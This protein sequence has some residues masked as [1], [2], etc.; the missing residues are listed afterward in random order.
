MARRREPVSQRPASQAGRAPGGNGVNVLVKI[1]ASM[2]DLAPAERRVAE[3]ALE[4]PAGTAGRTISQ[5]AAA[6]RTSEATVVRFCRAIGFSGYPDLRLALAAAAG[7]AD[8]DHGWVSGE[9]AADDDD[10]QI[11]EKVAYADAKAITETAQQLDAAVLGRVADAVHRAHRIDMYGAGASA[12]VAAD[13][14]Q[15]LHRIGRL[16]FSAADPHVASASAALLT[17]RDVAIA[18]SHSGSTRDTVEY[19][20]IA[21]EAGATTVALTNYPGSPLAQTAT[22]VLTTAARETTFRSGAMASRIAQLTVIDM[23]FVATARRS[24]RSTLQA[25]ERT[26]EAARR[27]NDG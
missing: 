12:F 11:V 25:L 21:R 16:A 22:H 17:S 4:D 7:Q 9:I 8:G 15:K 10:A 20:R 19:L 14:Q 26:Y 2:P 13:L 23:V 1:R 3:A 24:R 5:L 27:R 6:C 18:L